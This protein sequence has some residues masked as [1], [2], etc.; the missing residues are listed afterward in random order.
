MSLTGILTLALQALLQPHKM[1]IAND[2]VL[3]LLRSSVHHH[4]H[5]LPSTCGRHARRAL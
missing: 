1:V 5:H 4:R 2:R 3:D